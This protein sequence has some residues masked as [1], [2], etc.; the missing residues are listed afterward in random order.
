MAKTCFS[1][2]LIPDGVKLEVIE[3]ELRAKGKIGE[4]KLKLPAGVSAR[5]EASKIQFEGGARVCGLA[6]ALTR[7]L[8]EGVSRGFER[9]LEIYGIG[10][11]VQR[12]PSGLELSLGYSAPVQFPLPEGITA[13]VLKTPRPDVTELVLRGMDLQILG[14]V[15]A[16]LRALRPPNSYTGKGVRYK[17]ERV[18]RKVGKRAVAVG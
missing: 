15:A 8:L 7:N 1:P 4:L 3:G 6:R 13:E 18:R 17:G 11:R 9:R 14:L 12:I 10:Y 16:R 5:L 2:L